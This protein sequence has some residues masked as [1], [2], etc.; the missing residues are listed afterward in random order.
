M[1]HDAKL[2]PL[3]PGVD[4]A[5]RAGAPVHQI[6]RAAIRHVDA[7]HNPRGV[8]D[9]AIGIGRA[10]RAGTVHHGHLATMHLCGGTQGTRCKSN[11]TRD[12]AM[13]GSEPGQH[14][15]PIG[16]HI[17]GGVAQCEAVGEVRQ[18][19]KGGPKLGVH[20]GKKKSGQLQ[21]EP[22]GLKFR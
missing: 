7:E 20:A 5:Y 21:R 14:F 16:S 8:G 19:G 6:H 13:P 1:R 18:G 12:L 3:F 17:N 15:R 9:Q 4:K 22:T 10:C 11:F 2:G